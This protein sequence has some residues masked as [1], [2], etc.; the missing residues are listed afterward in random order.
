MRLILRFL[1]NLLGL[2][3]AASLVSGFTVTGNW[4][5][6]IIA[7]LVLTL[8]N[9]LVKPILKLITLPLIIISLGL[10]GLVINA[11]ILWLTSQFTGYLIIDNLIAL[12]WATIILTAVNIAASRAG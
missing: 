9:L 6:Y 10:F 7:A 5:G 3:L 12:W 11:V 8:L 1:L 2:W 4:K